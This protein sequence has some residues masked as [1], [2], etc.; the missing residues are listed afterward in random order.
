MVAALSIMLLH[1]SLS[2]APKTTSTS[3]GSPISS[4][5][6]KVDIKVDPRVELV[7]IVFRLAGNSEYNRCRIPEYDKRIQEHFA[8]VADHEIVKL[9]GRL[10]SRSGVSFDAPMSFAVRL[11][12]FETWDPVTTLTVDRNGLDE[13][14]LKKDLAGLLSFSKKDD[15][16]QFLDLL[17]RFARDAK[18]GEFLKANEKLFALTAKRAREL[19]EGARLDWFNT[20]FGERAGA[21]F[22]FLPGVANG[23]NCYGVR[24]HSERGEE[25]FCIL[26]VW[27][28]DFWGQPRFSDDMR[29]T[30][31]HEF[32]HSYV[33][34]IVE[35][36]AEQLRP[37]GERL[38]AAVAR[39]MRQQA[40]GNW[41]TMIVESLNRACEVRYQ[42]AIN[43]ADA[44]QRSISSNVRR[45]FRWTGEL[46]ALLEQYEQHRDT[47]PTL[48]TF[49]PR[50]VEFFNARTLDENGGTSGTVA[51]GAS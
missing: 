16:Q 38:F 37:A 51:T 11:P 22:H 15:L 31:V 28:T 26:G 19:V 13:R 5:T 10:R 44:A 6:I 43:G 41:R 29:G 27:K 42:A 7:S 49:F 30:V 17:P 40:Y 48:D 32:G 50:I 9:A 35:A 45:G 3:A 14:W 25:L 2:A 24:C 34:P 1:C 39:Q 18:Y 46:A 21:Q 23:P 47:Y 8:P 20:F 4:P 36:R 33:N 12:A